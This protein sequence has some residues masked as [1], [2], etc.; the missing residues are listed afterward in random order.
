MGY[1]GK[2]CVLHRLG[3]PVGSS[4]S[5]RRRSESI[6]PRIV[7]SEETLFILARNGRPGSEGEAFP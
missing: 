5:T 7:S 4:L 3:I 1:T 2:T 6:R